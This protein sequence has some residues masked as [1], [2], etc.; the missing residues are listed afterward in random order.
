MKWLP[1]LAALLAGAASADTRQLT[2]RSDQL[3]WEAVG[4]VETGPRSYCSGA[5]IAPKLV[6]TA[7]HCVFDRE[8]QRRDPTQ[9]EFR[10]GYRDGATIATARIARAVVPASFVPDGGDFQRFLAN[11]VA[12]LELASTIP[13]TTA[14]YF[15]LAGMP[16]AG[17]D[18]TAVSYGRGRDNA[19][20]RQAGCRVLA[21][22]SGLAAFSC[23][24]DP[25]SSGAP[26]FDTSGRSP[27]IVAVIS[28]T[29][30]Y[31]GHRAVFGMQVQSKVN[32]MKRALQ[33]G[34][35]VWPDETPFEARRIGAKDRSAGGARFLKPQ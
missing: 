6:L 31:D 21:R 22:S 3:G 25:G 20:T 12:L 24:G 7:A 34:D 9:M 13:G 17:S 8:G 10:A 27:R 4:R 28:S 35:G 33:T 26:I 18:V 32:E 16:S 19:A 5:L 30:Q 11:D 29:G 15:P 23:R 2:D 1:L 14:S